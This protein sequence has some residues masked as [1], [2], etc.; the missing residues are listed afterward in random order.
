MARLRRRTVDPAKVSACQSDE[1][2]WTRLNPSSV[3]S[4][5]LA[6]ASGFQNR[7]LVFRMMAKA[8]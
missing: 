5:M 8:R 6:A 1:N 4:F 3:I 2:D 7:K